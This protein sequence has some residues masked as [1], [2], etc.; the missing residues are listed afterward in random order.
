MD[1]SPSIDAV[2]AQHLRS[3]GVFTVGQLLQAEPNSVARKLK[4]ADVS[5]EVVARWQHEATLV[6]GVPQFAI[7]TREFL[8]AVDSPVQDS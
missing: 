1:Q 5:A 6:C 4:L 8:S 3:V 7:L 2:A